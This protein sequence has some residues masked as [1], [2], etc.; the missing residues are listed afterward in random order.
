MTKRLSIS[1]R[2]ELVFQ[3]YHGLQGILSGS[4]AAGQSRSWE[5]TNEQWNEIR[6]TIVKLSQRRV[7]L[8]E[9]GVRT[10][11][12]QPLMTY[13]VDTLPGGRPRVYQ[14]EGGVQI[15]GATQSLVVRGENLIQGVAAQLT[16]KKNTSAQ[17]VFTATRKGPVGNRVAVKINP[18]PS[19]TNA[20]SVRVTRRPNGGALIEVTPPD[21][22]TSATGGQ[23]GAIVTQ[24]IANAEAARFVTASGSGSGLVGNLPESALVGGDGTG[25]AFFD[26]MSAVAGSYLR[27]EARAPGNGGNGISVKFMTPGSAG[28]V[29]DA[30]AKTIIVTP[31]SAGSGPQIGAIATQ[32]NAHDEARKLIKAT[33]IGTTSTVLGAPIGWNYLHGGAGDDVVAKVG[34]A[35]VRITDYTDTAVTLG[36]E[37][38]G[39]PADVLTGAG[40]AT[41]EQALVTI[42]SDYGVI[43]AGQVEVTHS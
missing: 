33:G 11:R 15:D 18:V 36:F 3:D 16:S 27:L 42:L 38:S 32:I 22:G 14:I 30:A 41:G 9:S 34:G 13:S 20:G 24:L 29:V 28:I 12:F 23:A 26:V 43:Q 5:M 8:I 21:A 19:T 6:Q 2:G 40:L 4:L 1:A 37:G 31:A 7:E 17:I 39:D 35:V 25:M 10:G